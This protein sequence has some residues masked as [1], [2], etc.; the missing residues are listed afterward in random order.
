MPDMHNDE[1]RRQAA[2]DRLCLVDSSRDPRFDRIARLAQQLLKTPIALI[3]FVDRDRVW[4]K[5]RIGI[6]TE[7]VARDQ[8]FCGAVVGRNAPLVVA[9]SH[10]DAN[11]RMSTLVQGEPFIRAYAG[12]PIHSA[13]NYAIGTLCVIDRRP[14]RFRSYQLEQLHELAA[15]LE[16]EI[17]NLDISQILREHHRIERE[18]KHERD[19]ALQLMQAM[20]QGLAVIDLQRRFVYINP[21]YAAL[22]GLA[23][24]AIIGRTP[25]DFAPP[26]ERERMSQAGQRVDQ[27]ESYTRESVIMHRDGT[28]IPV[29]LSVTPHLRNGEVIGAI[30]VV[31][32]LRERKRIEQLKNDFVATVSH[33]LRTPLTSIHGALGL[34]VGGVAGEL[35]GKAQ[36]MASI[37]LKNSERLGRL[38]DDI[39]D[40]E[41]IESGRSLFQFQ[42]QQLGP[43]LEQAIEAHRS[44][45]N[46]FGVHLELRLPSDGQIPAV[47]IDPDRF[48]Q[49]LANLI[50][51][52]TKF[53]PIGERVVIELIHHSGVQRVQ[54]SDQG[55]GIPQEFQQRIFQ[56]FAQADASTTRRQ[57]GTGLGLSISRAIVEQ[58]GGQIGFETNQHGTTF[59]V[60]LPDPLNKTAEP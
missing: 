34:L 43:L 4:F 16:D 32:D 36:H 6:D 17:T 49:V 24:E 10:E 9:D 51:N 45:A 46:R 11:F 60:D 38:I 37:A 53:S 22:T 1:Q 25:F 31:T 21:A 52:A 56:K 39:L 44:Y 59:Y 54:V 26:H 20:G 30:T 41:K 58:L 18:L 13:T 3:S 33:E 27:G 42:F 55:P 50:S 23:T 5:S 7:Q 35:P 8:S 12:Y 15:L 48:L 14:R 47:W 40:I 29:L 28:R 57:G 19:F 2:L